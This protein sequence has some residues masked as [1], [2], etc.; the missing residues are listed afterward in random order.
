MNKTVDWIKPKDSVIISNSE[1]HVWLLPL[2]LNKRGLEKAKSLLDN[3]EKTRAEQ[4]YFHRH[5][6]H[7]IAAR[8]QMR[9]L[10]SQYLNV[11][12]DRIKFSYNEFGKPYLE[13]NLIQFNLSHSNK[14][15]LFAVNLQYE[16]GV[17]I[18]WMKRKSNLLQIG[19][20]FFSTNEYAQ[21]KLLPEK[22]QRQGF[23]NCWTRK[24]SYIKA[25]GKGLGISLSK[26]EVSLIPGESVQIKSTAHEPDAVKKWK[27]Y[28]FNPHAEYAAGL[29]INTN[30]TQVCFWDGSTIFLK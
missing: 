22:L 29:T 5:R 20:R 25:R 24:E 11:E 10:L 8:G 23:F 27:L 19:K 4:F 26:F 18:E 21:L 30:H 9:K 16:L 14:L 6:N 12:N 1:T 2:E 15:A 3:H 7:Y 13:K 28:A 17:D